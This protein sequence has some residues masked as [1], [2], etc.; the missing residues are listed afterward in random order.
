MEKSS[1]SVLADGI[2]KYRKS[3]E[4]T[5]EKASIEVT[6]EEARSNVGKYGSV[7]WAHPEYTPN[8]QGLRLISSA[9]SIDE[10][11]IDVASPK[12]VERFLYLANEAPDG[13]RHLLERNNGTRE[14]NFLIV[15]M[16]GNNSLKVAKLL[17][18][19]GMRAISLTGGITGLS[20]SAGKE[21][22]E[23][24]QIPKE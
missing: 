22:S 5:E 8:R 20:V 2:E 16:S 1:S 18:S 24:V 4:E 3:L 23:L 7:L 6:A 10:T 13:L 11:R 21:I 17:T 19:K 9:L 14:K 15:C 12:D